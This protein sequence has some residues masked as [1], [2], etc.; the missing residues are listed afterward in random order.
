MEVARRRPFLNGV[1]TLMAEKEGSDGKVLAWLFL[2]SLVAFGV[3]V[4]YWASPES[5]IHVDRSSGIAGATA[6]ENMNQTGLVRGETASDLCSLQPRSDYGSCGMFL[7]V[8][9]LNGTCTPIYGCHL[10]GDLPPFFSVGECA[11][12]C[13]STE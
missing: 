5:L 9:F 7:G 4:W 6:N 2:I 8:F 1:F 12:V 3:Y 13:P 10:L 11:Q